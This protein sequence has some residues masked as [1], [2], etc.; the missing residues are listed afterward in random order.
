MLCVTLAYKKSPCLCELRAETDLIFQPP[1]PKYRTLNSRCCHAQSDDCDNASRSQRK[2]NAN[3]PATCPF[4]YNPL[5]FF[6][7]FPRSHAM[8][9][10]EIS[11][12]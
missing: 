10:T 12:R 11:L 5:V 3:A 4:Q 8:C 1:P 7:S 9:S 6:H 2:R